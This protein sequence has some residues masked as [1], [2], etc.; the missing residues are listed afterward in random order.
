MSGYTEADY[1]NSVIELFRNMDY[2]PNELTDKEGFEFIQD[3]YDEAGITL[4]ESEVEG[5]YENATLENNNFKLNLLDYLFIGDYK[6]SKTF[7]LYLKAIIIFKE[8]LD[9]MNLFNLILFIEKRCNFGEENA[10]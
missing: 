8:K 10:K 9:I 6:K 5:K 7:S 4:Y 1:E 2:D 3:F